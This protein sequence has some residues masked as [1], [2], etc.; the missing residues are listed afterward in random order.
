MKKV[1]EEINLSTF[2]NKDTL[3]EVIFDL[4]NEKMKAE[5]R[6]KLLSVAEDFY[7]YLKIDVQYEDIWLVGSNA[8]YNWSEYSDVDVHL[9]IPFDEISDNTEFIREYFKTKTINWNDAHQIMIDI[10]KVETY[11]QDTEEEVQSGGIYSILYDQWIR[12][13]QKIDVE[14]DPNAIEMN[15]NS[16]LST[17]RENLKNKNDFERFNDSLDLLSDK[18]KQMRK[19]GL[20]SGGEFDAKN[21]AFK[22]LRRL[23][24]HDKIKK[25]KNQA[26]DISKS[27]GHGATLG[28]YS[29]SEK[30][31]R[32]SGNK[33]HVNKRDALTTYKEKNKKGDKPG[34]S[35]GI[36]YSIHGVVFTS[37]REASKKTGEKKSTIQYRVHSKNPKYNDYKVIYKK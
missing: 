24:L 14:V 32:L 23:G 28:W 15:V 1:F 34:Y 10:H 35:D 22:Y 27:I 17:F 11:V 4:E 6:E 16:I 8:N 18:L 20:D 21:L 19:D 33:S 26:Y 36:F 13:P 7:E 12:Y 30:Q 31:K 37:L 29:T 5:V 3:N 9:I 25:L 2:Q